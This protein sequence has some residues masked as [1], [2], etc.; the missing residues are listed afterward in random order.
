MLSIQI[1]W[2]GFVE[3]TART[4]WIWKEHWNVDSAR[5][6]PKVDGARSLMA[7]IQA[8][9]MTQARWWL[10]LLATKLSVKAN[11]RFYSNFNNMRLL[12]SGARRYYPTAVLRFKYSKSKHISTNMFAQKIKVWKSFFEVRKIKASFNAPRVKILKVL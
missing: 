10:F 7:K 12:N 4:H 5:V 2:S 1:N 6:L 11:E 3:Q 8:G 9:E